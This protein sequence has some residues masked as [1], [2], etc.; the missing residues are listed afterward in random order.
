MPISTQYQPVLSN[1]LTAIIASGQTTSG[2][3]DLNGNTLCGLFLPSTFDGSAITFEA[4]HTS[5]GTYVAV[6]DG[7]GNAVSK[8]VSA[9]KYITLNPADFA[10]IRFLRLVAGTAQSATDTV[11]TLAVRPV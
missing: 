3:I 1:D 11:I 7:A 9:S 10:G 6:Q 8:T 5:G 2:E 4:A